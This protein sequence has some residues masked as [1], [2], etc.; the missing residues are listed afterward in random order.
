MRT[1][2]ARDTLGCIVLGCALLLLQCHRPL[3]ASGRNV[4]DPLSAVDGGPR[5][6]VAERDR[7]SFS[8]TM[9]WDD[10]LTPQLSIAAQYLGDDE[11]LIVLPPPPVN[12]S[13]RTRAELELLRGYRHLRTSARVTQI[14]EEVDAGPLRIGRMTLAD[15]FESSKLK[16]TARAIRAVLAEVYPI[17]FRF[18]HRFDRVRPHLLD[19]TLEPV[20]DVPQHPA[21]PS[22]H[23]TQAHVVAYLLSEIA[24]AR[25]AEFERDALRIAVNREIA[26]VHYPSDTAAGAL[27][28]R[29]VLDRMLQKPAFAQLVQQ[30]K[31]E[32]RSSASER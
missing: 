18:K 17:I 29:Q 26:G 19:T 5:R 24:P 25:R 30:A 22:G 9:T 28:A 3:E 20:I 13:E 12:S 4:L 11:K 23:S 31:A 27:L 6:A 16:H 14:R 2:G 15:Y 8:R 21:Y 32:W 10:S 1:P 7:L